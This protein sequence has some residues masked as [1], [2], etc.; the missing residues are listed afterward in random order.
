MRAAPPANRERRIRWSSW[1]PRR[2]FSP[3]ERSPSPFGALLV[4]ATVIFAFFLFLPLS[5]LGLVGVLAGLENRTVTQHD[6]ALDP[7]RWRDGS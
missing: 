6:P 3:S 4:F 1:Q 5:L 7:R 2:S